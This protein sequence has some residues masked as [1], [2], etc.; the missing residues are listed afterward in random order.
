M[1]NLVQIWRGNGANQRHFILR[2]TATA[3]LFFLLQRDTFLRH[4]RDGT[5]SGAS[6]QYCILGWSDLQ[7]IH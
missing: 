4:W 2:A 7:Y 1:K 6:A 5:K 3:P